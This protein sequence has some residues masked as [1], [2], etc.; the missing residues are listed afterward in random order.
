MFTAH[1]DETP[2]SPMLFSQVRFGKTLY[3]IHLPE[4][5]ASSYPLAHIQ[6]LWKLE[7]GTVSSTTRKREQRRKRILK[8][9]E[10]KINHTLIYPR[11]RRG[12][13]AKLYLRSLFPPCTYPS[14][15]D[16]L[17]SLL[18]FFLSLPILSLFSLLVPFLYLI[19]LAIL[20]IS[21]LEQKS[22]DKA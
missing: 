8:K 7:R 10:K 19:L 13:P 17:L 6:Y 20:P 2:P 3:F 22:F 21:F 1:T 14:R 9:K 18:L 4:A 12:P 11:E 15:L 16:L 5:Y